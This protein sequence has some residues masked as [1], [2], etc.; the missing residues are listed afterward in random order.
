[1]DSKKL[2]E[3]LTRMGVPVYDNE[4]AG[5]VRKKDIESLLPLT[6]SGIEVKSIKKL[7]IDKYED[8][9]CC[10]LHLTIG[11]GKC[12]QVDDAIARNKTDAENSLTEYLKEIGL[13]SV[14]GVD[15][16]SRNRNDCN[17]WLDVNVHF[18]HGKVIEKVDLSCFLYRLLER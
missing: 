7:G 11:G 2:R 15:I 12:P 3:S 5:K 18:D 17:L 4:K 10:R 16:V 6:S 13:I 1:M 14:T 9:F 8:Y